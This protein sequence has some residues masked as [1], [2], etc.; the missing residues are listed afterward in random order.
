MEFTCQLS[1]IVAWA[2][3]IESDEQWLAWSQA[4]FTPELLNEKGKPCAPVLKAVPAM[5]RRRLSYNSKLAMQCAL[6]ALPVNEE[7]GITAQLP[8]VFAS[9]QGELHKT[10]SLLDS[11][12]LKE[13][14]SP[15][16]FSL[17]VHNTAAGLYSI[18][19]GN[20]AQSS[21]V[22]AQE[23]TLLSGLLEAY[24]LSSKEKLPVL[25]VF[26]EEAL[27]EQWLP[28]AQYDV[29]PH[30]FACLLSA[31]SAK[32]YEG[33]S[34]AFSVSIKQCDSNGGVTPHG[35]SFIQW[36]F[37]DAMHCVLNGAQSIELKKAS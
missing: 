17:S 14:V 22:A 34:N 10:L 29:F 11:L 31:P 19:A 8:S 16:G 4:P 2:P 35:L 33:A 25:F 1:N 37:G 20:K 3:H 21:S 28:F 9:P 5:Q 27:P 24:L 36:A 6:A 7:T 26:S 15:M 12:R 23:D 13:P 32:S 30:A 18:H